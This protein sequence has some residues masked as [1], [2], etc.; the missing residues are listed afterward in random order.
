NTL[1][2]LNCF[3]VFLLVTEHLVRIPLWLQVVGRMHPMVLHFPIVMLLIAGVFVNFRK[4]LQQS[5][6]VTRLVRE[7]LFIA[8]VSA[9]ITVI[10]GLLPA[11][12]DGYE[13]NSFLWHKWTGVAISFV[14][15]GLV[16]AQSLLSTHRRRWFILS[17][18]GCLCLVSVA[19][20]FGANLSHG[21]HCGLSPLTTGE[22]Q[23][24][25]I[26]TAQV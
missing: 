10:L 4:P 17:T 18:N 5:F 22:D 7:T 8:A 15:C 14:S 13:G 24:V 26:Q 25:D 19:G 12:E 9:A 1:I 6:P 2:G 3:I 20:H 16:W 23:L 11:Q 21:E